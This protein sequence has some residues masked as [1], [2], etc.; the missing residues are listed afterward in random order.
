MKKCLVCGN[1]AI[2]IGKYIERDHVCKEYEC[3]GCNHKW[4][5]VD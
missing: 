2:L 4:I 5:E 3:S 1:K